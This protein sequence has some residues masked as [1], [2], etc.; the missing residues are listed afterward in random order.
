ML[1]VAL[2][3]FNRVH[4]RLQFTMEVEREDKI[5]FLEVL[6]TRDKNILTFDLYHKPTFSGKFLNFYSHHPIT[7]KRGVVIGLTD[8]ILK[9]TH[10]KYYSKNFTETINLLRRNGYPSEFIFHTINNRIKNCTFKKTNT[11]DTS[12][13]ER[14][15]FFTVPFVKKIP[16]SLI[17]FKKKSNLQIAHTIPNKLREYIKTGK[18][19]LELKECCDVVYKIN[20]K[21]CKAS[22]VGQTKR[23]LKTRLHEHR[24][25]INKK[26]GLLS[27]ISQYRLQ[28]NHEFDWD[29]CMVLDMEPSY[30]K[31]LLSE[32]VNIK[33]QQNG[34]NRATRIF[35]QSLILL[36]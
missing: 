32:I 28:E 26:S 6:L 21:V 33:L 36:S 14:K 3:T 35:S 27:V 19:K 22:Y 12:N 34:L 17:T 23:C 5:S 18:D 13:K 9:L 7:H 31:R 1:D 11:T 15:K 30:Y 29:N 25:D 16:D 10:P 8:K 20:C 4:E 2:D 24:T